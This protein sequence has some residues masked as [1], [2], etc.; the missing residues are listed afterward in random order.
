[1]EAGRDLESEIGILNKMLNSLVDILV[2]RGVLTEA[3]WK[4]HVRK[5]VMGS[6]N[7]ESYSNSLKKTRGRGR[8]G[9]GVVQ[10]SETAVTC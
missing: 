10:Y 1:M 5:E 4:D 6:S 7:L 8:I 3:E 2:E 9:G